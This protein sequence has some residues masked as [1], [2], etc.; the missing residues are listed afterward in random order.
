M[1]EYTQGGGGGPQQFVRIS[2]F[3]DID[4]TFSY[5]DDGTISQIIMSGLGQIV[6][7]VFSYTNGKVTSIVPIITNI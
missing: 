7:L 4:K 3:A 1:A 2:P 5:N 6:T